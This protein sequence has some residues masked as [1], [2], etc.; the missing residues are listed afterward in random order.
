[1][2][3]ADHD[4]RLQLTARNQIVERHPEARALQ[5]AGKKRDDVAGKL[6]PQSLIA[7]RL[8][9]QTWTATPQPEEATVVKTP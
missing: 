6:D 4:R 9:A 2:I 1:M 3:A 7:A 8:A 5:D